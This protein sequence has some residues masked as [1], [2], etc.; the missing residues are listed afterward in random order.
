M[1]LEVFPGSSWGPGGPKC[2]LVDSLNRMFSL[3]ETAGRRP[4]WTGAKGA[5][6]GKS[7]RK[8]CHGAVSLGTPI[9]GQTQQNI[10]LRPSKK[11]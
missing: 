5:R 11:T 8:L 1:V 4:P 10:I 7:V 3:G 6:N 2:C 9:D